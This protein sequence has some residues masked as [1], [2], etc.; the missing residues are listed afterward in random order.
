MSK[1]LFSHS[2]YYRLDP[3]QWN[4]GMPYPPLGTIY[5][6]SYMRSLGHEVA[7]YDVGLEKNSIGIN[8]HFQAE[9]PDYLV[10]YDDGF[11]YLTKMCLT[12]MREQCFK[13]IKYTKQYKGVKIIVSSSDSTDHYEKYL[14][15][16]ADIVL[17]GE[18]ELSLAET[19]SALNKGDDLNNVLGIAFRQNGE[20]KVNSRRPVIREL[21]D[22]PNPAWDLI[23]ID[24]YKEKWRQHGHDFAINVATT[25]GCPYKCNWCAK[26]IYGNRY[27]SRSPKRVIE[28]IKWLSENFNVRKLWMCDDIFGLKPNWVQEFRDEL[29][30]I[31]LTI[32]YKIQSRA[33]LL[34]KEDN[35]DALVASGL[36]EVWI[37]AESGSQNILD[38]M[39]KGTTL[40]QIK[41]STELLQRKGVRVAY[42]LQFGY[43]GET[44]EDVQ[45]TIE[46]LLENMPDDIGV[47]VSY[48]L[49]G[50]PFYD[51][52]KSQL[53]QK[54]N[55]KDS[56]DL[57]L[58]FQ[59]TFNQKY[60]KALHR[61]IHKKFRSKQSG[62]L[63]KL[64]YIPFII[65][66]KMKMKLHSNLSH[67]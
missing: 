59:N 34:L 64:A 42:F 50:T 6:A 54:A 8:D 53:S 19:I 18:G 60:Y 4:T 17:L 16:G 46:M 52:V 55:W 2:Y 45:K 48:P 13:M 66:Y 5:A 30:N 56:D 39:D 65:Y 67:G 29:K 15:A 47:S 58:M 7:L 11:N 21:D 36:Y 20:V 62:L 22:L 27:N 38:A 26:P 9:L 24:P 12:N 49:P 1:L 33:D 23:D 32:Q 31:G 61:F 57:A 63:K 35:I 51:K 28:E 43:L 14:S 25:R 3:K 10:I 37:G 40:D 41:K 44:K